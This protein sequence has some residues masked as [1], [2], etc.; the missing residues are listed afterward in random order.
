MTKPHLETASPAANPTA[1]F[2][3][4]ALPVLDGSVRRSIA[5]RSWVQSRIGNVGCGIVDQGLAAGTIFLGNVVLA[6]IQSKEEYGMF[7]LSYSI[8][9]FLSGLHNAAILEA[10]TVYGSGKYSQHFRGYLKV[11]LKSNAIACVGLM[12]LLGL[13]LLVPLAIAPQLVS[14][15]MWGLVLTVGI[16][17]SAAFLRRTFYI[18]RQP[19]RAA[20]MSLV[21]SSVVC[22]GLWLTVRM[23]W[24]NSFS[25]FIIL[26]LGWITA[27]LMIG[28]PLIP[29][30]ASANFTGLYP[31]HWEQH[32]RY[33][34]WVLATSF[35]FQMMTQGYYWLVAGALSIRGVAELRAMYILVTPADQIFIALSF[36]V[37]PRLAH[38]YASKRREGFLSLWKL[39]GL[40]T[41]L[42]TV[43]L[44]FAIRVLGAPLVHWLY[45]GKFDNAL[46]LLYILA[47]LPIVMGIGNTMN[48]ALK[49]MERPHVVFYAYLASGLVTF[50]AGWPLV[51]YLGVRGAVIGMLLSATAYTSLLAAGF[52]HA[53]LTKPFAAA[54]A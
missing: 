29:E 8:Y 43:S 32:W 26:A 48:D 45:A 4:R 15:A 54:R 30:Q 28:R 42:M 52:L 2:S 36:L 17:L 47:G 23:G 13:G 50:A 35:V 14:K 11:M 18:L 7:V 22:A 46:S 37:L 3:S 5:R 6:R 33:A 49:S 44:F 51:K 41:S 20:G 27:G 12:V 21:F 53:L 31:K 34:R 16:L 24:L 40:S 10:Y 39:Y 19:H 1:R 9:T 25:L 38:D